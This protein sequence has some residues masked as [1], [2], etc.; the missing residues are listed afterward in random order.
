MYTRFS[1]AI[2]ED[3]KTILYCWATLNLSPGSYNDGLL[4]WIL[5]Q[6]TFGS[7]YLLI[8]VVFTCCTP[9]PPPKKKARVFHWKHVLNTFKH[10]LFHS[11]YWDKKN[12]LTNSFLGKG[13]KSLQQTTILVVLI[14]KWVKWPSHFQ[15]LMVSANL[16]YW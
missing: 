1:W 14:L 16:H 11:V 12:W 13:W 10:L 15:I 7:Y 6:N 2:L 9:P 8:T 4:F 5:C 3:L